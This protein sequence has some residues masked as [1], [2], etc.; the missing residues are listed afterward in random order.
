MSQINLIYIAGAGRSGSTL[1]DAILGEAED[2]FSL[3]EVRQ[4]WKYLLRYEKP[5]CSCG[6]VIHKCPFWEQVLL[7]LFK[8]SIPTKE[9]LEEIYYLQKTVEKI[10]LLNSFKRKKYLFN[11]QNSIK[12]Y[13]DL[14]LD[15]YKIVTEISGCKTLIDSS[16]LPHY[17]YFLKDLPIN[18]YVVHLVR[19]PRGVAYSWTKEK[20]NPSLG[21]YMKKH[22]PL[23]S[24]RIWSILNL[25]TE[26]FKN[27][28]YCLIKYEDLTEHLEDNLTFLKNSLNL[29]VSFCIQKNKIIIFKEKHLVGG[30]PVRFSF[31]KEIYIK[32]DIDWQKKLPFRYKILVSLLTF[33]LL[34][35]Y[36]YSIF[37]NEKL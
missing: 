18:L 27:E 4:I 20:F 8:N 6:K 13:A 21:G 31:K 15:L 32:K 14:T 23:T 12:K 5:L 19:D 36:G 3:G 16:K 1:L 35:K 2:A 11:N 25:G 9:K 26:K 29:K 22:H 28:N 33:P 24:A 17:L 7:K 30:N 34:K 37:H 10:P